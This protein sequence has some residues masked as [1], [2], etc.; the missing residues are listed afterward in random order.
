MASVVARAYK[1]ALRLCRQ[2]PQRGPG[3]ELLVRGKLKHF[4]YLNVQCKLQICPI[5]YS[6]EP[7][8]NRIFVLYLQKIMGG[9]ET[10]GLCP[11]WLG[12]KT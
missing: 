11:P 12:P 8:R 6:L 1:G 9:H 3:A 5:F 2:S 4:W 10:G 7:Q